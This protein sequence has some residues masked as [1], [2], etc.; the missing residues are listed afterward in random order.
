AAKAVDGLGAAR[1]AVRLTWTAGSGGRGLARPQSLEPRLIVSAAASPRPAT[2]ATAI[3]CGVRRNAGSPA[4]RL[5]T[6]SYLDNVLAR[7]EALA[8]GADE[9]LM[10][11][12]QGRLACASAANLFWIAGERLFTPALSCGVLDGVIRAEVMAAAARRG[13]A[14]E[15]V[16]A[17]ASALDGA[18]ALFLTSSLIGVR[19]VA[20]LDGTDRGGHPLL[21]ALGGDLAELS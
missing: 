13:V 12:G 10:L 17:P 11:D 5:K 15:E 2:P 6:L 9:A 21:E 18:Q 7:R 1:A 4:S 16:E 20:R 19:R 8:R 14:V 3:V